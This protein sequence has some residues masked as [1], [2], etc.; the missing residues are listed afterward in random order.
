MSLFN[1]VEIVHV[2]NSTET[3]E[4]KHFIFLTLGSKITDYGTTKRSRAKKTQKI[5]NYAAA[6]SQNLDTGHSENQ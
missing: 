1:Q 2:L 6:K 5:N 3:L 4:A